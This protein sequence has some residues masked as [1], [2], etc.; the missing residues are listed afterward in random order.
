[1]FLKSEIKTKNK[2]FF[3]KK[4]LL[5]PIYSIRD[6]KDMKKKSKLNKQELP[7]ACHSRAL[8]V[9]SMQ[10]QHQLYMKLE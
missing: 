4:K 1:M 5:N 7:L 8:K 2:I 9:P 10:H 6:L 3:R